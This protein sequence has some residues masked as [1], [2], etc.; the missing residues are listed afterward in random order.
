MPVINGDLT[1]TTASTQPGNAGV[2]APTVIPPKVLIPIS[3]DPT[4]LD[5]GIPAIIPVPAVTDV[6][7]EIDV[8][9]TSPS[10]NKELLIAD[11]DSPVVN[12]NFPV[13]VGLTRRLASPP[14]EVLSSPII[15]FV[16]SP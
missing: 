1:F 16:K 7:D 11:P 5:P 13:P 10:T 2:I 14:T 15:V 9:C 8:P 12:L 3:S 4:T 6:F